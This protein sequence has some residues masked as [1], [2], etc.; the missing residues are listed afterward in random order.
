LIDGS[1]NG[2]RPGVMV[3]KA[4]LPP[5]S[6]GTTVEHFQAK[7]SD[8]RRIIAERIEGGLEYHAQETLPWHG[9]LV[10]PRERLSDLTV[11]DRLWLDLEGG[12]EL[13]ILPSPAAAG[14]KPEVV[15]AF[16]ADGPPPSL[17]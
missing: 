13:H 1:V 7:L 8:D 12:P 15:V 4:H 3:L 17:S 16:R 14:G 10:L 11:S 9:Y 5:S 2:T 6:E